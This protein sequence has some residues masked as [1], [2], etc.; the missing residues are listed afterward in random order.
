MK[1]KSLFT[2][3][4]AAGAI[5]A[6]VA[7]VVVLAVAGGSPKGSAPSSGSE[8]TRTAAVGRR[9][10]VANATLS[11][12]QIYSL[13]SPGVVS[14]TATSGEGA[15]EGTGIVLNQKGLI[16]TNDHV[17]A[18]ATSLSIKTGGS[19]GTTRAASLVGE[20]ANTD[21]ALIR[22]NPEGLGLKPLKMASSSGVHVGDQ[23]Y[24]IGNPYG[25][26]ETLTRGI[27]SGLN[28]EIKAP[29]G[30]SITGALQTDAA[31]NPGN[32]GGPLINQQGEVIGINSQIAS[33]AARSEGSQPG[34]TGVGF[35]IASDTAAQ[36]VKAIESGHTVSGTGTTERPA[37][38]TEEGRQGG[39]GERQAESGQNESRRVQPEQEASEQGGT[40]AGAGTEGHE[41]E[42]ASSPRLL[43]P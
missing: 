37:E 14:I 36:V 5:S 18:G 3:V 7:A 19:S 34:S 40:E 23:V 2:P 10:E 39:R 15:D 26:E 13:D 9:T 32:S 17:V 16:L 29:D 8:S 1:S 25:L 4:L 28:R 33:D 31:L 6:A 27:V 42:E 11:A 30:S 22:V 41:S 12:S 21:L 24:A 20:E 38:A 35:A 43:L